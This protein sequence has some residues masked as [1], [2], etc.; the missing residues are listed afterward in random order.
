MVIC[1][2]QGPCGFRNKHFFRVQWWCLITDRFVNFK[3]HVILTLF[4][5]KDCQNSASQAITLDL[6]YSLVFLCVKCFCLIIWNWVKRKRKWG[7]ISW[8]LTTNENTPYL[9]PKKFGKFIHSFLDLAGTLQ[10]SEP[11]WLL[12][13]IGGLLDCILSVYEGG[14][15]GSNHTDIAKRQIRKNVQSWEC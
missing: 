10:F 12:L 7:F 9:H 5:S 6:D 2:G 8:D 3:V 11:W 4:F 1:N 13:D 15:E 14:G